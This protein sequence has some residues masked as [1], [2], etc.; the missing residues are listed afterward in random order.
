MKVPC[1]NAGPFNHENRRQQLTGARHFSRS[2]LAQSFAVKFHSTTTVPNW[3]SPSTRATASISLTQL[4]FSTW[5]SSTW[6]RDNTG[7][8]AAP[9]MEVAE[10]I[11]PSPVTELIHIGPG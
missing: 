9:R 7:N 1:A 4:V 5:L 2:G 8:G 3:S 11:D 6:L 10:T